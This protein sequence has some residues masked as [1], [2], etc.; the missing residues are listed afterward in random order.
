MWRLPFHEHIGRALK[1]EF[2]DLRNYAGEE[3]AG[4]SVGGVFL[5]HFRGDAKYTHIDIAGP[6]YR[7]S[8]YGY[9]PK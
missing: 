4:S 7:E 5:S 2:A 6:S 1:T 8:P 9:A 3:L